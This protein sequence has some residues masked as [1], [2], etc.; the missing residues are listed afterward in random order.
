MRTQ[1]LRFQA[2]FNFL[3]RTVH[4]IDLWRYLL[5]HEQGGICA[6]RVASG[7]SR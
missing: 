5:L 1:P 2:L 4:K 7:Q 3:P 6:E